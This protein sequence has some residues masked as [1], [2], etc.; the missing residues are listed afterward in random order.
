MKVAYFSTFNHHRRNDRFMDV[1]DLWKR[2]RRKRTALFWAFFLDSLP[3]K[4][5]PIG[6]PETPVRN[7]HY[8][9][10][11]SPEERS[12]HPFRVRSLKSCIERKI[13]SVVISLKRCRLRSVAAH[14]VIFAL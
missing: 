5:G 10:R 3:L 9:L 6:C 14:I 4:I 11:N 7:C 8:S 1:P 12:S 2:K 13:V